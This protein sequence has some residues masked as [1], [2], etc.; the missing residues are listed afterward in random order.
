MKKGINILTGGHES[1]LTNI[2]SIDNNFNER[3]NNSFIKISIEFFN[4]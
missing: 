2:K 4:Q 3:L 1:L